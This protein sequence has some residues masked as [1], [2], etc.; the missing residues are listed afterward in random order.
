MKS[1]NA[2]VKTEIITKTNIVV[3]YKLL[4][5]TSLVEIGW[6]IP[7]IIVGNCRVLILGLSGTFYIVTF[8]TPIKFENLKVVSVVEF[9]TLLNDTYSI[10]FEL[11]GTKPSLW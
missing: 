8:D 6:K 10:D 1:F 9:Y 2:L 11:R 4:N 3:L 5:N 7:E